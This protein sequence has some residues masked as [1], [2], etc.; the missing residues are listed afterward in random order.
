[1]L[2]SFAVRA[3]REH[4]LDPHGETVMREPSK[5][6]LMNLAA[7]RTWVIAQVGVSYTVCRNPLLKLMVGEGGST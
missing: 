2:E 1:M 5:L 3:T 6:S 7:T 4:G